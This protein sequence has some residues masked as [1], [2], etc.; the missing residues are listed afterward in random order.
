MNTALA[1]LQ[2]LLRTV[3]ER[4][5]EITRAAASAPVLDVGKLGAELAKVVDQEKI[6]HKIQKTDERFNKQFAAIT[7]AEKETGEL[8]KR[9]LVLEPQ[10]DKL[11]K[12]GSEISLRLAKATPENLPDLLK[13]QTEIKT[14]EANIIEQ[15]RLI[16]LTLENR[17]IIIQAKPEVQEGL[18]KLKIVIGALKTLPPCGECKSVKTELFGIYFD[19]RGA[20]DYAWAAPMMAFGLLVDC[21]SCDRRFSFLLENPKPAKKKIANV[22]KKPEILGPEPRDVEEAL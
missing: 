15:L 10:L 1:D 16:H 12:R 19:T 13:E 7:G 2:T 5:A 14:L 21:P 9:R 17:R 8:Q 11:K 22:S 18:R 6:L 4:K 3:Q 20:E